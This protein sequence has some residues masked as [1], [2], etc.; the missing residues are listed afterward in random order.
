[1]AMAYLKIHFGRLDPE[2]GELNRIRRGRLDLAIDGGPDVY[3]AVYGREE[4]DGTLSAQDGDTFVM[5][6]TW[7]RDGNLSSESIHQFGSA[8]L[9]KMSPHYA[10]QTP[11]FVAM[12]TKPPFFSRTASCEDMSRRTTYRASVRNPGQRRIAPSR[13]FETGPVRKAHG[14]CN[15]TGQNFGAIANRSVRVAVLAAMIGRLVP[16]E[17]A[18]RSTAHSEQAW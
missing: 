4:A 2:W 16:R 7:N 10:D 8:T 17:S 14:P 11:T 9:D 13:R 3:R 6:V 5:F 1:M 12:K 15:N 18:R